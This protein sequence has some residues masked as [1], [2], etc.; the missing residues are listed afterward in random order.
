MSF[1]V[2]SPIMFDEALKGAVVVKEYRE[3][4][5]KNNKMSKKLR[6]SFCLI[7]LPTQP[8]CVLRGKVR[9]MSA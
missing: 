3:K 8:E 6:R 7:I 1:D 9:K 4:I 2:E 5:M